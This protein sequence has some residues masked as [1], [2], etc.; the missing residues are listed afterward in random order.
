MTEWWT[1]R[2]SDFLLFSAETY[3]RLFEL[4]NREFWPLHLVG[5][6]AGAAILFLAARA[7]APWQGR[8]IAAILALAW[9]WVGWAFLFQ[10]YSGINWAARW[11]AAAFAL[12]ALMLF[13]TMPVRDVWVTGRESLVTS[14]DTRLATSDS[15]RAKRASRRFGLGLFLF[16]LI[17][18]PF[19][20]VLAGRSLQK[21]ETFAMTPDPTCLATIGVVLFL[22][23]RVRILL[24]TIPLL[25]CAISG[26]TLWTLGAPDA[27]LLPVA[28][29]LAILFAGISTS[30]RPVPS[31]EG[32]PGR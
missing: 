24:L 1:Y 25:W 26:L 22:A 32:S 20:G 14:P 19:V 30:P 8:T 18:Q 12:Q 23:D 13:V 11:F 10:R 4:Y 29:F 27:L 2:P 5:L 6:A 7:S 16:A 21:I 15:R 17:A 31:P 28:G 3:S 9:L